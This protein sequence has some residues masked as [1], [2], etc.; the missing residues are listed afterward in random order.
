MSSNSSTR[1]T[2]EERFYVCQCAPGFSGPRCELR[3]PSCDDIDI[4]QNGGVCA[5]DGTRLKCICPRGLGGTVC[6]INL[7]N[8]CEHAGN[9]LNGGLCVDGFGNYT[10]EC[11]PGKPVY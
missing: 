5:V 3:T 7:V 6:E 2:K 8:E 11:P 10:C 4:C 1:N 9:C